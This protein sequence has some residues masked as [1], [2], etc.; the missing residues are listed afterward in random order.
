MRTHGIADN[1]CHMMH[2]QY[3]APSTSN[4]DPNNHIYLPP[5]LLRAIFSFVT[6]N[7]LELLD[8][9][10]MED[11]RIRLSH[12]CS[13][14]RFVLLGM[15]ELWNNVVLDLNAHPMILPIAGQLLLRADG[16]SLD[17]TA[18]MKWNAVSGPP[19]DEF[20]NNIIIPYAT[21]TQSLRLHLHFPYIKA[22]LTLPFALSFPILESL[23]LRQSS[24]NV[25]SQT[26]VPIVSN[27]SFPR[28]QKFEPSINLHHQIT[29]LDVPQLNNIQWVQLTTFMTKRRITAKTT[30]DILAACTCLKSFLACLDAIDSDEHQRLSTLH[31]LDLPH[32][33]HLHIRFF[34]SQ[35][36]SSFFSLF[37]LPS[38]R[39]LALSENSGRGL[40]WS[41]RLND[42]LLH[43]CGSS[44]EDVFIVN[45]KFDNEAAAY[46]FFLHKHTHTLRRL[47]LWHFPPT[48]GRI[49]QR[50]ISGEICPQLEALSLHACDN[51]SMYFDS[52]LEAI[53]GKRPSLRDLHLHI[54]GLFSHRN[55]HT[56]A[57]VD[58]KLDE[59]R[60]CGW[61][62][63][64]PRVYDNLR[65]AYRSQTSESDWFG[66]YT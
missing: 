10:F 7:K 55:E 2:C 47:S 14:W 60:S 43:Q 58:S 3:T 4:V 33:E 39:C 63:F 57:W 42:F 44:L 49:I 29:L 64:V 15:K 48:E 5:E 59:I 61:R 21:S 23:C 30:Y 8:S 66:Y 6:K 26:D 28:L 1:L 51:Y 11:D 13:Y 46:Q 65:C 19:T 38:I 62:V 37:N 36:F 53:K 35:R 16:A 52:I 24:F 50:V 41:R 54:S 25:I 45:N 27:L 18:Q 40:D 56:H 17:I 9:D 32:L 31:R 34:A 12:V 22:L 20:I